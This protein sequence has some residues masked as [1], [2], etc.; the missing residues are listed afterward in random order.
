MTHEVRL[1]QRCREPIPAERL[2]ALPETRICVQCSRD[3]GG[4]FIV[5][6]FPESIGKQGSL[7]K[8]YG[9]WTVQKVRKRIPPK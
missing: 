1:C 6:A 2:E 9:G 5:R 4:E 8:N 7:K 3:I